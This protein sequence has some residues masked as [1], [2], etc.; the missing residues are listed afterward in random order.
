MSHAANLRVHPRT[1]LPEDQSP[2]KRRKVDHSDGAQTN[3]AGLPLKGL[4][5]RNIKVTPTT[6]AKHGK[7]IQPSN[8][9]IA[10]VLNADTHGPNGVD[11]MLQDIYTPE[12][13]NSPSDEDEEEL[14]VTHTNGVTEDIPATDTEQNNEVVTKQPSATE[15]QPTEPSFGD[16]LRARNLDQ[17]D[18]EPATTGQVE[19]R[20]A[21]ANTSAHALSVPSATSLGTVLTQALR[22]N[23]V[24]LLE[25]CLQVSSLDSIRATVQ[26]LHPSF[27]ATLLQKLAE[28]LHKRPGRAGSLMVWVQWTIVA[29]GGYLATQPVAMK[30]IHT[31]YSVVKQ[32]ANGLQ[33]LLALKGRLDMLEAQLQMRRNLQERASAAGAASQQRE[34]VIYVEGDEGQTSEDDADGVLGDEAERAPGTTSSIRLEVADSDEESG[35]MPITLPNGYDMSEDE[36]E[37]DDSDEDEEGLINDEAEETDPES[38]ELSEEV[39]YEDGM[40]GELS[41]EGMDSEEDEEEDRPT[42][43]AQAARLKSKAR[44]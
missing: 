25:S 41:D 26:R 5:A 17:I 24:D 43:Q 31:L 22:T 12:E 13:K 35:D 20:V 37:V 1:A 10:K 19:S 32:R 30:E 21:A 33:P 15:E 8:A 3:G 28:R 27:A 29:H 18:V 34:P 16:L 6:N 9:V 2:T 44:R 7:S 23:D 4:I 42:K 38:D 39:D 36:E 11:A 40:N 14:A